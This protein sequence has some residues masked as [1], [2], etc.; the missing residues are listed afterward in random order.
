MGV[1]CVGES[2][3]NRREEGKIK[4]SDLKKVDTLLDVSNSLCKIETSKYEGNGFFIKI[5]KNEKNYFYLM[6]NEHIISKKIIEKKETISIT[7]KRNKKIEIEL[8]KDKRY[9]RDFRDMKIDATV[10]E[11]LEKD[12]IKEKYFLEPD[13]EYLYSFKNLINKEIWIPQFLNGINLSRGQI[14]LP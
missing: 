2:N 10:V 3:K 14:I 1:S 13:I 6:S 7:Y 11:I 12:N 8:D 9:I 5:N 4:G